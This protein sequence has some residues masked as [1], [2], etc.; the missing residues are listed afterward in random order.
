MKDIAL[1]ET[2]NGGDFF[3]NNGD[4]SSVEILIH[5]VYISLFGG[6]IE[7]S[8]KGNEIEGQKRFDWWANSLI[9]K[10]NI[11]RQFNSET[12]R[13]L[14]KVAL[15]SS[16]R[17]EIERAVQ[18]DLAALSKIVNFEIKVSIQSEKKVEIIVLL[19]QIKNK[20]NKILQFLWDS[21]KKEVIIQKII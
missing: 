6:N 4:I 21:A 12:E 14:N 18:S 11:E 16:G 10:D 13:T 9:F 1:Y 3:L 15:N 7:D 17:N 5:Q 19:K 20:E 2:G 8:T